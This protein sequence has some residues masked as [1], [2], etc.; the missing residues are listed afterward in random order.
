MNVFGPTG[1][2]FDDKGDKHAK[3]GI[4]IWECVDRMHKRSPIFFNYLYSPVEVEVKSIYV[5]F[6]EYFMSKFSLFG[7]YIAV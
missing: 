1:T 5:T 6:S 7:V 2:L 4:C 3:K